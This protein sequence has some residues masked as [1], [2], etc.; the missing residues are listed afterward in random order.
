MT[1]GEATAVRLAGLLPGDDAVVAVDQLV[2]AGAA[3]LAAVRALAAPG[4]GRGSA[5]ARKACA[6][7]DGLAESP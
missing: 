6:L 3:E 7:A 4:K 1:T 2:A 5:R